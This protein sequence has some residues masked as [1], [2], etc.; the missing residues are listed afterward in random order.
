MFSANHGGVVTLHFFMLQL[1][2]FGLCF[3]ILCCG[4]IKFRPKR[5]IFVTMYMAGAVLPYKIL[6]FFAIISCGVTL[7]NVETQT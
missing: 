7:A 2:L 3:S 6:I 1:C 4:L 5:P